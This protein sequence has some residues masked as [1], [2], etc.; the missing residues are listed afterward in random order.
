MP[1]K[2]RNSIEIRPFLQGNHV[3]DSNYLAIC[4]YFYQ[5]F[6]GIAISLGKKKRGNLRTA[7]K[8]KSTRSRW[9]SSEGL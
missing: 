3:L 6:P 8:Y 9:R 2:A 1:G 5:L 4:R 7:L